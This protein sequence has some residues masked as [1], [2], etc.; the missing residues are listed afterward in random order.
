MP[1][2]DFVGITPVENVEDDWRW[3][4][5]RAPSEVTVNGDGSITLSGREGILVSPS[6]P[7]QQDTSVSYKISADLH[8][9]GEYRFEVIWWDQDWLPASTHV[10]EVLTVLSLVGTPRRIDGFAHPGA[11]AAFGQ[12]R[13]VQKWD[14]GDGTLVIQNP[15]VEVVARNYDPGDLLLSLDAR[16]PGDS[17][18]THWEDLTG[19]NLP[20]TVSYG[21]P[22]YNAGPGT[23]SFNR[24]DQFVGNAADEALYDFD[25][26]AGGGSA[27]PYTVVFYASINGN[28]GSAGMINKLDSV[29]GTATG[30]HTG[31]SQDEFGLNNVFTE[32]RVETGNRAI[33][34]APGS[35]ADP[36]PNTLSAIGVTATALNLYVVHISGTGSGLD[37]ADVYIN[38]DTVQAPERVYSFEGLHTGS[39]LNDDPL[40]IGGQ[41]GHVTDSSPRGFVGNIQ[42]IEIWAGSRVRGLS[43]RDYSAWR[44]ANLDLVIGAAPLEPPVLQ[45]AIRFDLFTVDGLQ[46]RLESATGLAAGDWTDTGMRLVG[47]GGMMTFCYPA[48]SD[49]Q[50]AY[51]VG[52]E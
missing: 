47:N 13:F 28:R 16:Q 10:E 3:D 26:S 48:G 40:R 20:F 27:D 34:R 29:G 35:A 5:I 46:Y 38:G 33:I 9:N 1:N 11:D 18:A 14:S 50:T 30:W 17:P 12:V 21:A 19:N 7:A 22:V 15:A 39:V 51:R 37:Q 23:Y 4:P 43:P 2:P 44:F 45:E 42:F 52:V 41:T 8:G 25:V 31:L 49:A 6:F 24:D 36:A 32:Q